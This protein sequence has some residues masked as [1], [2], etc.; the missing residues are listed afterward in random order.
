MNFF[1][2]FLDAFSRKTCIY[3]SKMVGA[4]NAFPQFQAMVEK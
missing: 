3:Y 1:R 2:A 4:F